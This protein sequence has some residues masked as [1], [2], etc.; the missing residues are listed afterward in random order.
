MQ[1]AVGSHLWQGLVID[2]CEHTSIQPAKD[3]M[4]EFMSE[5][6][7]ADAFVIP[8]H[9]KGKIVERIDSV[10]A[11]EGTSYIAPEFELGKL[12]DGRLV[13]PEQG[14]FMF[15][16]N[17][18]SQRVKVNS[19]AKAAEA[20]M[21]D[22][23]QFC[24]TTAAEL[25][26]PK[27]P[28]VSIAAVVPTVEQFDA[29]TLL[30]DDI[31]AMWPVSDK[32]KAVLLND[33]MVALVASEDCIIPTIAEDTKAWAGFGRGTW[34]WTAD[35]VGEAARRGSA[36]KN[37]THPTPPNPTAPLP[38]PPHLTQHTNTAPP[39]GNRPRQL[40]PAQAQ[41]NPARA[42]AQAQPSPST[43]KPN[44]AQPS[45]SPTQ[46]NQAQPSQPTAMCVP[47]L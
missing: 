25:R 42:K 9:D 7:L 28:R 3:H 39:T 27:K 43:S 47:T 40:N 4:V 2:N 15:V 6:W 46:P 29:A 38:T 35:A 31:M 21:K 5:L 1:A 20:R 17:S 23:A 30:P 12:T 37:D 44:Q 24:L 33:G 14:L 45:P 36:R 16:G 10:Q 41:P 11:S 8:N 26:L 19:M 32:C 34:I 13:F 18:V 22:N